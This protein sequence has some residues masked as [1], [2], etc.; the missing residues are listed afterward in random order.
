MHK[1]SQCSVQRGFSGLG[2][3]RVNISPQ[4]DADSFSNKNTLIREEFAQCLK[5][6]KVTL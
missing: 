5:R 1:E 6:I 3:L 2:R 4:L